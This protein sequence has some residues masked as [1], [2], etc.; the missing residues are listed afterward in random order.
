MSEHIASG[1]QPSSSEGQ[2]ASPVQ[3]SLKISLRAAAL[4]ALLSV[5]SVLA[6][7]P[8]YCLTMTNLDH[9]ISH[10]ATW[11]HIQDAFHSGVLQSTG[12][13]NN[14]L[15]ASG[16]R[17]TD[18]YALGV[19]LEPK[20]DAVTAGLLASRPSSDRHACADLRD[21]SVNPGGVQWVR[22]LRYWHGYRVYSAPLASAFP[23]LAV[24]LINLCLLAAAAGIFV[25]ASTSIIGTTPTIGLMAPVIFCSDFIRIWQ[26]TPHVVSTSIILVGTALFINLVKSGRQDVVLIVAAALFGSLFNFV[27]FLVNPPWMPMLLAFFVIARCDNDPRE[28]LPLSIFV[29]AAWVGGYGL[30]WL[31]KWTIAYFA[32]PTFD[33]PA[34]VV[35][36]IAFRIAGDNP[37]VLI[38]PLVATAKMF[39]ACVVSWG[40]PILAALVFAYVR[41]RTFRI[42]SWQDIALKAWP[43]LIPISWFEILSN[44]TQIHYPFVSRSAAAAT[45]V[46]LAAV[47]QNCISSRVK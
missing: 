5:L 11:R 31:S 46:M 4:G 9:A 34:D 15:I 20:V 30:T 22:Y 36:T 24:K 39:L 6:L 28:R 44:H 1:A 13:S 32:F 12:R 35:S 17:F 42:V 2:T 21:A 45:G 38:F 14:Q 26:V 3:P 23:I 16:D 18:C 47:L 25:R 41:R 19:G 10:A 37:K 33:V 27:D 8:L 40:T 7:Q 43:A 29:T